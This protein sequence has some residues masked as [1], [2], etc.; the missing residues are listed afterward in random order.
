MKKPSQLKVSARWNRDRATMVL[1]GELDIVSEPQAQRC[2]AGI[3]SQNPSRL[4]MDLSGLTFMGSQGLTLIARAHHDLPA[5]RDLIIRGASPSIRRMLAIT[6]IDQVCI[7]DGQQ[8]P[9]A[10]GAAS[11]A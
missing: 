3:L 1:R 8:L 7:I 11:I 4:V 9:P 5:G 10:P 6:G 2:L